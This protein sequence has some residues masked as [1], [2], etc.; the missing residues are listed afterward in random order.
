MGQK[1]KWNEKYE[2]YEYDDKEEEEH[3]HEHEHGEGLLWI[4][5]E[6]LLIPPDH[7]LIKVASSAKVFHWL[8]P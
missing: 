8:G 5:L 1:S 4:W 3:E 7:N 2:D 6:F